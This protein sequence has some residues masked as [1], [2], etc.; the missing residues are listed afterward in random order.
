M[1]ELTEEGLYVLSI[2]TFRTTMRGR[3]WLSGES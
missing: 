1:R 3:M 2:S